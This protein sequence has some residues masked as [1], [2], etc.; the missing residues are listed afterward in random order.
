MAGRVVFS[1]VVAGRGVVSVEHAGGRRTTY[2]PL[3]DRASVG[4][5]VDPGTRIGRLARS[6]SHCAPDTCLHWGLI[7][8]PEQYRDPLILV[9]ARRPVILLPLP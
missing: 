4:T 9:G 7:V 8:G 3:D 2:E 1:G 5:A 6:G